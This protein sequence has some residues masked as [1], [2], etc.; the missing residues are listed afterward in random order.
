MFS[1]SR[2]SSTDTVAQPRGVGSTP[3]ILPGGP[4]SIPSQPA[5][6]LEDNSGTATPQL[7]APPMRNGSITRPKTPKRNK[8][9]VTATDSN[10]VEIPGDFG[11]ASPR[12]AL[13]CLGQLETSPLDSLSISKSLSAVSIPGHDLN[14]SCVNISQP[15]FTINPLGGNPCNA[16]LSLT[17][18][19]QSSSYSFIEREI[20]P[21]SPTFE[22]PP[23]LSSSLS[24]NTSPESFILHTPP[25]LRN[26]AR[27]L[28]H[29]KQHETIS[30][31]INA[32]VDSQ[33][34][35]ERP[36]R[37]ADV[38]ES[39]ITKLDLPRLGSPFTIH[40]GSIQT[41]EPQQAKVDFENPFLSVETQSL[42]AQQLFPTYF[43]TSRDSMLQDLTY[44]GSAIT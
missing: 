19:G 20:D 34:W 17:K 7:S 9:A 4:T 28:P 15:R 2:N 11:L 35:G 43:R 14:T 5:H 6:N 39:N 36:A 10:Q 21:N 31:D 42:A 3:R 13:H 18:H 44:L 16:S 37:Y 25:R 29:M 30:I 41:L 24:I 40:T 26:Q 33:I 32:H 23:Q 8:P 22:T 12:N 38:F 1:G 27:D